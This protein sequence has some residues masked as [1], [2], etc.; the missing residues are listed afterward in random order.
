M[1]HNLVA[2]FYLLRLSF[3]LNSS[4]SFFFWII[5]EVNLLLFIMIL[6]ILGNFWSKQEYHD[7]LLFYFLIQSLSSIFILRD[8]FFSLDFYIFNR[9]YMFLLAML[10]KLGMF[11]F[12]YWMFKISSFLNS[13]SLVLILGLQKIPFLV[14]LFSI[15][16]S[17]FMVLILLSFFSGRL[18]ILFSARLIDILI[19]SSISYR[20]WVFYLYTFNFYVFLLFFFFILFWFFFY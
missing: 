14:V 11:P 6:I 3:F 18:I 10:I 9:D 5:T 1:R 20:F 15:Q 4:S 2:F 19:C 13:L 12:F 16:R 8:F 7:L 17:V